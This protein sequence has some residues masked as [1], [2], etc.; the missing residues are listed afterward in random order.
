[1]KT[2]K[3]HKMTNYSLE[4]QDLDQTLMSG[5]TD[6]AIFLITL[7]G[8]SSSDDGHAVAHYVLCL[9]SKS[10]HYNGLSQHVIPHNGQGREDVP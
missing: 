4:C 5:V 9:M 10:F 7:F 1:M 8:I 3:F 6:Y 2:M